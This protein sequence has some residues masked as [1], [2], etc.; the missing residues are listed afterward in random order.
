[1]KTG[2]SS[3]P[4]RRSLKA[5]NHRLFERAAIIGIGQI[6]GSLGWA[7]RKN[8][9]AK[10]VVG[11]GRTIRNLRTALSMGLICSYAL[12]P[13]KAVKG[14]DLVVFATPVSTIPGLIRSLADLIDPGAVV[15][16]VGSVKDAVVKAASVLRSQGISFIGGHPIAGTE[17]SGA[18]SADPGL[19]KKKTVILTP[20][21]G[22]SS[23]MR[24]VRRMWESLG[25]RVVL[26]EP[27]RHDRIMALMSH[28]PHLLSYAFTDAIGRGLARDKDLLQFAGGSFRDFTRIAGSSPEMWE[29]I[30]IMNRKEIERTMKDLN[31][32]LDTLTKSIYR[33]DRKAIIKL[34]GS[35][36]RL[37]ER[38]R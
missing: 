30:F 8:G 38:A 2:D 14:A 20:A 37:A 3:K 21:Y 36:R 27:L 31:K 29:S 19:F 16:D 10:E 23:A 4:L 13:E 32:S 6:G 28:V 15:T 1:M 33:G 35:V 24:K 26:M 18:S 34:L 12:T 5:R 11:A 25:A 17:R 9:L 22:K 7:L